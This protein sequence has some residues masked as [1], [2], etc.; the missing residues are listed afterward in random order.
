M[1]RQSCGLGKA[2]LLLI[3]LSVLQALLL[4]C[5]HAV[6]M[7]RTSCCVPFIHFWQAAAVI[8]QHSAVSTLNAWWCLLWFAVLQ[9]IEK[10][11]ALQENFWI[12]QAMKEQQQL[13]ES[14]ST[15]AQMD[16]LATAAVTNATADQQTQASPSHAGVLVQPSQQHSSS[17]SSSVLSSNKPASIV[18]KSS[19]VQ[20]SALHTAGSVIS[21]CSHRSGNASRASGAGSQACKQQYHGSRASVTGS[22]LTTTT[23]STMVLRDYLASCLMPH[24]VNAMQASLLTTAKHKAA[25]YC[26]L[27]TQSC[28]AQLRAAGC[29]S[30]CWVTT[31]GA[32]SVC[33]NW[34]R[35]MPKAVWVSSCLLRTLVSSSM[36]HI[37]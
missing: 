8:M 37:G 12:K 31:N 34:C 13:L 26:D 33:C 19:K 20:H 18:S 17:R 5:M 30:C 3:M 15:K 10:E 32:L 23:V 16:K 28:Q 7:C 36:L 4:R 2:K 9:R 14:G 27:Y 11:R 25:P 21:S 35:G 24:S 22:A 6:C 1:I 29:T